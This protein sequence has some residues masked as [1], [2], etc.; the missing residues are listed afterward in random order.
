MLIS[1][2]TGGVRRLYYNYNCYTKQTATF[3]FHNVVRQHY[4][5]KVGEFIN[6][7]CEIS[8]L[9]CTPKTIRIDSVFTELF[10]I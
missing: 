9:Y 7:W 10:K 5:G 8:S 2:W 1:L 6:F 3:A 4:S